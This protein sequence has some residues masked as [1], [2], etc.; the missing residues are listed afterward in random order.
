MKKIVV[1]P[2][3]TLSLFASGDYIPVSELS[4]S[5]KEEYNFVNKTNINKQNSQVETNNY[6]SV[7]Q[8]SDELI[9]PLEEVEI[10]ETKQYVSEN[11][12]EKKEVKQNTKIEN[13][14]F[15]KEYKKENILKDEVKYSDNSF[16]KN[17][18]VTPKLSYMRLT[19]SAEEEIGK[20]NILLPEI[21]FKYKNHILKT[22]YMG[23]D[24]KYIYSYFDLNVETS[25]YRLVYLYNFYNANI[26][27][28]YNNYKVKAS[29]LGVSGKDTDE[30][31]TLEIHAKN[32]QNHIVAEYGGFYGKNDSDI[33][34]AYEYYLNLGYEVIKNDKLVFTLGYKNRTIE[35]DDG[36]EIEYKGPTVGISSTF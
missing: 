21:A 24:I 31:V 28:A 20:T 33:E 11:I 22:D 4:H 19:L 17:F 12:K 1:L 8:E 14:T 23:V 35:F 36:S 3:L 15:V 26:G 30:F 7:S 18:S 13:K 27:L 34:S 5:K 10:K 2:F 6:K 9:E 16:S 25:W 29:L 32:K